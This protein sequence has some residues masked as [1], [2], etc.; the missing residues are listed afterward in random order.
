MVL[1]ATRRALLQPAYKQQLLTLSGG[2]ITDAVRRAGVEGDGRAPSDYSIGVWP[3]ISNLEQAADVSFEA[4]TAGYTTGGTNTIDDDAT[5]AKFGAK[6]C[7]AIYQN[8]ATLLDFALTAAG[9]NPYS[10]SRWL[11]I[12]TAYD[13]GG[14]SV[15]LAN[16]V[17]A[18]G[19]LAVAANMALR[20]QWQR[21]QV[22]NVGIVA[23]DLIGNV[24]VVNT[25]AAPTAGRF[26]YIDGCETDQA[27]ICMPFTLTTRTAG[28]IQVPGIRQYLNETEGAVAVLMRHGALAVIPGGGVAAY[29]TIFTWLVDASNRLECVLDASGG[30]GGT[31]QSAGVGAGTGALDLGAFVAGDLAVTIHRWSATANGRAA[32]GSVFNSVANSSIPNLAAATAEL[33]A[34]GANSIGHLRGDLLAAAFFRSGQLTDADSA[35]INRLLRDKRMTLKPHDLPGDCRAIISGAALQGGVMVAR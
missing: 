20:D 21:V 19:T 28:R 29:R 12:P 6:S 18:T 25:G 8:N 16:F 32:N 5:Q 33:G 4:G 30:F 24:Q 7:L 23:G 27:S 14:V 1:V 9:A 11:W 31:R 3:A 17:G 34:N 22:P 2:L 26:I 10:A 15:Q 13:G 35:A